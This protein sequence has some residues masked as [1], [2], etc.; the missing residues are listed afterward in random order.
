M[1]VCSCAGKLGVLALQSRNLRGLQRRNLVCNVCNCDRHRQPGLHHVSLLPPWIFLGACR[2]VRMPAHDIPA[3][4]LQRPQKSEQ[5]NWLRMSRLSARRRLH[6]FWSDRGHTAKLAWLVACNQQL[7]LFALHPPDQL[8]WWLQR[9]PSLPHGTSVL[10]VCDWLRSGNTSERVHQVSKQGRKRWSDLPV[11]AAC[12]RCLGCD[13]HRG[14]SWRPSY[15][16]VP[17]GGL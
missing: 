7:R 6:K 15:S 11:F 14:Y 2:D 1:C 13:F 3:H 9:V 16:L 5:S 8:H 12:A 4:R 10:V 17:L